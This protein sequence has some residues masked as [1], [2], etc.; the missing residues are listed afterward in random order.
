MTT[1]GKI[2]DYSGDSPTISMIHYRGNQN[3]T[4]AKKVGNITNAEIDNL[5]T[6]IKSD[7]QNR[8]LGQIL[9]FWL[10]SPKSQN[11]VLM[12]TENRILHL[13]SLLGSVVVIVVSRRIIGS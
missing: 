12:S 10:N 6:A 4:L 11:N 2:F 9:L 13:D 1:K 3:H 5:Y 8:M 7:V